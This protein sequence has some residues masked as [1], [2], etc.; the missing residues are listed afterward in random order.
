MNRNDHKWFLSKV[1]QAV[2][3][4]NMIE[5]GDRV[6]VALSGGKDSL[7]LLWILHQLQQ[8]SHLDFE[9]CAVHID[10][11]WPDQNTQYM[12]KLCSIL[13][14]PLS[15]ENSFIAQAISPDG[16]LI[17]NPC[18]LCSRLRRGAL[19]QWAE[20]NGCRKI[21]LGHHL[22]DVVETVFMNLL[23]GGRYEVFS[24]RIDYEDRGISIIRPL[25]YLDE[26]TCIRIAEREALEPMK[27]TCPVNHQTQRQSIKDLLHM[28]RQQYPDINR[29]VLHSLE[30]AR[31]DQLWNKE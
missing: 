2:K 25:V 1:K 17:D 5:P 15:F 7:V 13:S 26:Q 27:N 3:Q 22:D 12:Q 28:M 18:A 10:C 8:K 11:G 31:A 30:H 21:A 16:N 19:L 23:H 29:K 20:K 14:I 9:L 4:Y 6:A 24:P